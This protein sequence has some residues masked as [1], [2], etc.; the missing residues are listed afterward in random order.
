[1][2]KSEWADAAYNAKLDGK[3]IREEAGDWGY[4][5]RQFYRY[6]NYTVVF[7]D[8]E[9]TA[10]KPDGARQWYF[11]RDC[12]G[13]GSPAFGVWVPQFFRIRCGEIYGDKIYGSL[14]EAEKIAQEIAVNKFFPGMRIFI[15]EVTSGKAIKEIKG[16]R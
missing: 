12:E 11:Y 3:F 13:D 5:L 10:V 14:D 7:D 4:D 1:M 8:G 2:T 6:K 16:A 15:V 9:A